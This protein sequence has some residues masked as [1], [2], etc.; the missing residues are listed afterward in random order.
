MIIP[1]DHQTEE[2]PHPFAGSTGM[3]PVEDVAFGP[4]PV[5]T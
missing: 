3:E 1:N 5:S 2:A 4:N